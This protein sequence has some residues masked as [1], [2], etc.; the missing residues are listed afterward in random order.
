MHPAV[1]V[2]G[3]A[4]LLLVLPV[5]EH[6][7]VAAGAELPRLAARQRVAADRVDDLDL[8]VRAH[9]ADGADLALQRVVGPG[10]GRHRRRL[11]HAVGDGHLV[12]ARVDELLHHLLGARRARHDAG[13]H[14]REVVRR[15]VGQ[16]PLGDEHRRH[17]VERRALLVGD[18]AQ[19]QGRVEAGRRDHHRRAVGGAREV[20]HHHP[21]AVVEGHR[22][23]D[24]VLL[25]VAAGLADEVAVV[26]DV[27]VAERRALGE[28]GRARRV[29]DVDR[30]V[31]SS[32][33]DA[34]REVLLADALTVGDQPG[35]ARLVVEVD[36]PLERLVLRRPSPRSSRGSRWS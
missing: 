29:L 5:A 26:E 13:A 10:L 7:R 25:G 16:R 21:E 22:D 33:A 31:G 18:R 11:G 20:A 34:L 15:Q 2:D 9:P 4:G 3:L 17:A 23:A 36:D 35:P 1:R 32:D 30:V 8:Q 28:A 19:G 12:D 14:A 6:H 24:P 27:A